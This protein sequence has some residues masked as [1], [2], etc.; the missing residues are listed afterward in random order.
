MTASSNSKTGIRQELRKSVIDCRERGLYEAA[1]WSAQQLNALPAETRACSNSLAGPL[2]DPETDDF[3]LAKS[4]FDCREYQRC[5]HHLDR[6]EATDTKSLFLKSYALYLAGER[7]KHEEKIELSGT[8]G[9]VDVQNRMLESLESDLAK[10]RSDDRADGFCLYVYGLVLAD[11]DKKDLAKEVLAESVTL[12]ACNWS[13]WKALLDV[14]KEWD[15]VSSL[16]LPDHAARDFFF[17][18]MSLELH[19]NGEALSRMAKLSEQFPRSD[20]LMLKAATAHY[21]MRK[22]DEAQ[23]LFE[24]LISHDEYQL[25]G[26]DIFSN[27]LY[28]KEDFAG[29]SHLAHR[30]VIIDKYR[31]ETCCIIGNY[32]SLKGQHEKAVVYFQR[33]LKLDPDCLEAWTLIGHEYVEM[34]NPNAA[35][36]AYRRAVDL[37][38]RDFRAW[39]GLGQTY[40]MLVMPYY[41]LY[42][43][44][45]AAQLRPYDARMWVAMGQCYAHDNLKCYD[46]AAKCYRRA[47]TSG[48]HENIV[49]HKLAELYK[50]MN[51]FDAAFSC[52]KQNLEHI[53]QQNDVGQ[54]GIDA[55]TFMADY[56]VKKKRLSEAEMYAMRLQDFGG[57]AKDKGR[58]IMEQIQRCKPTLQPDT[59]H[60]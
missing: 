7:R 37:N 53:D 59:Q 29:L 43:F 1:A 25:D 32:Y 34:K 48:D 50:L 2:S 24:D 9:K 56:C 33:A 51:Q 58:Q 42:Y 28:M 54:D 57:P 23:E 30:A 21:N 35:I 49:L 6:A 27:I 31:P 46:A 14:C 40:E 15:D 17:A 16:R 3:L 18:A 47:V 52:Y 22:M 10:L 39:Y 55:L 4:L 44:R 38:P 26:M 11:R 13:A 36:E 41:A 8:L 12:Y 60:Y 45:R 20:Y 5:A 19:W